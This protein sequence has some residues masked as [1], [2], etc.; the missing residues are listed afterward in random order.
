MKEELFDKKI[1]EML[2]SCS[3]IPAP[4]VWDRIESGIG[5]MRVRAVWKRIAYVSA[6]AADCLEM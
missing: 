4:E 5:R 6:A 3:E 2:D 1:K